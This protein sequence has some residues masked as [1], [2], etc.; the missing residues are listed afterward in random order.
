MFPAVFVKDLDQN[1]LSPSTTIIGKQTIFFY[2]CFQVDI[3]LSYNMD[4]SS[5]YKNSFYTECTEYFKSLRRKGVTD[6]DF[7]DEFFYTVRP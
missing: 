4:V 2:F 1:N 3:S 6:V 5:S 7:E